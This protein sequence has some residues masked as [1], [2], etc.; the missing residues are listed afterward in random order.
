MQPKRTSSAKK[1][2]RQSAASA[3]KR[4]VDSDVGDSSLEVDLKRIKADPDEDEGRGDNG[5]MFEGD[6]YEGLPPFEDDFDDSV[7]GGSG[8]GT[9]GDNKGRQR[10]FQ[11]VP[12]GVLPF[13]FI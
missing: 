4:K 11:D 12:L 2:K 3:S 8:Q 13:L 9:S 10:S 1:T 6:D 5:E 7:A